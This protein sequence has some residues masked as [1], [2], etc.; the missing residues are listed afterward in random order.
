MGIPL[1]VTCFFSIVVFIFCLTFSILIMMFL[2]CGP[3]YIDPVWDSLCF[4]G[5]NVS[6]SRL[7]KLSNILSSN[8]FSAPFAL[9]T[10]WD[11]YKSNVCTHDALSIIS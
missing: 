5:L 8:I 1:Y 2:R 11:S 4:L 3:L 10:F 6:F 7:E 9:F